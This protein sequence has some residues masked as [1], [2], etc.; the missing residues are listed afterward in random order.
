MRILKSYQW[1]Y[2]HPKTGKG[3]AINR[4]NARLKSKSESKYRRRKFKDKH[5]SIEQRAELMRKF[6]TRAE[7][8]LRLALEQNNIKYIHQYVL[9]KMIIDF[10]LPEL[11]LLVEVDDP[12]HRVITERDERR[13]AF[14]KSQGYE[15]LR[16]T[17][18]Q[19]YDN[20]AECVERVKAHKKNPP[21]KPQDRRTRNT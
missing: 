13:D 4:A 12:S 1:G 7:A 14:A 3:R 8:Y 6:P 15:V 17:N 21:V 18:K 19:V 11:N 9:S 10:Y 16:L 5:L 2:H 20:T